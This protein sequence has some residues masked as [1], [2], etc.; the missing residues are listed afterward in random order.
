MAINVS[1]GKWGSVLLKWIAAFCFGSQWRTDW[2]KN[3]RSGAIVEL[4]KNPSLQL[5]LLNILKFSFYYKKNSVRKKMMN[6]P[7]LKFFRR[8]Y[9]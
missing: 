4:W 5:V 3:S 8:V 9:K 1:F 6:M 7:A 2:I